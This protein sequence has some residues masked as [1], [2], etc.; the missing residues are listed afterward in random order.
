VT[1]PEFASDDLRLVRHNPWVLAAAASPVLAALVLGVVTLATRVP[2]AIFAPHLVI[3]GL[4]LT[5]LAYRRKWRP[6]VDPVRVQAGKDGVHV[7]DRFVPRS[8]ITGGFVVPGWPTRVLLRLRRGVPVELEVRDTA[9]ARAVLRALGLDASQT[10]AHFTVRSRLLAKRRYGLALVAAFMGVYGGGI[11]AATALRPSPHAGAVVMMLVLLTLFATLAGFLVPSKLD[12]GADGIALHWLGTRRF[13]GYA[14][15][16]CVTTYEKGFGRSRTAGLSFRLRSGEELLVPVARR[17]ADVEIA[18]IDERV[19]EAMKSF[20]SGEG[21]AEGARLERQGR[22]IADWVTAL[23]GI[24][25]GAD[26]SLRTAP[27]PRDRLFRIVEDPTARAAERAAAA[28]A[29]GGE[30]DDESRVRLRSVAEA[31]AAPRLR[32]AIESAAGGDGAAMEAALAELDEEEERARV[33]GGS[34]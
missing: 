19:R 22:S 31:T 1:G 27:I 32:V 12:V 28:V 29:L 7:G 4:A 23:R 6:L 18:V 15:I 20:E 9:E 5:Y 33:R 30:L 3:A 26:A 8:R 24:G 11:G 10:V 21:A 14:Q 25:A 13:I 17:A 16:A 2:V 34:R